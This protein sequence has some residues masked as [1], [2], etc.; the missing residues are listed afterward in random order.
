MWHDT[1]RVEEINDGQYQV[2]L[3]GNFA[4]ISLT[5]AIADICNTWYCAVDHEFD[6]SNYPEWELKHVSYDDGDGY[7]EIPSGW[8]GSVDILVS[9]LERVFKLPVVV[10]QQNNA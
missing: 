2:Y 8:V 6:A 1:L 5:A 9:V 10:K 3:C 4:T 7:L